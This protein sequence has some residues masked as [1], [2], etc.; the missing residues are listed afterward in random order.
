M[1]Q[2]L[3]NLDFVARSLVQNA[4]CIA[5]NRQVIQAFKQRNRK[6]L[7]QLSINF[8]DSLNEVS[9]YKYFIH[10]HLPGPVS[11][12]RVW[13]PEKYGDDISRFRKMVVNVQQFLKPVWGIELGR[14]GLAVRG[15][16]PVVVYEKGK[17]VLLGSIEVFC[18]LGQVI[19]FTKQSKQKAQG[20]YFVPS[21]KLF[22]STQPIAQTT[23]STFLPW[24]ALPKP[25]DDRLSG[26]FFQ[27]AILGQTYLI[28]NELIFFGMP[29][30]DYANHPVAIYVTCLACPSF[31]IKNVIYAVLIV[32]SILVPII[33]SY[34]FLV[35]TQVI[36][37]LTVLNR[38]LEILRKTSGQRLL[39]PLDASSQL[40][41]LRNA[42]RE[43]ISLANIVNGLILKMDK[44]VSFRRTLEQDNTTA[45]IYARLAWLFKHQFNL[46]NF[47]IF[48]ISNSADKMSPVLSHFEEKGISSS[49]A[50]KPMFCQAARTSL[51]ASTL[52][53]S[54]V[55]SFYSDKIPSACL[56]LQT[57]GRVIAVVRFFITDKRHLSYKLRENLIYNLQPYLDIA[58]GI[59]EMKRYA[60]SLRKTALYDYLTG[61]YNRHM[62]NDC[63]RRI[64]SLARRQNTI[65]G[66]LMLDLDHF[67]RINDTYGHSAGDKILK[68][69]ATIIKQSLR[70]SDVAIRFGGEEFLVFLN[71]TTIEAT[72]MVAERIRT[73]VE[74]TPLTWKDYFINMTI[75]I[76]VA[77]F[78]H[79]GNS[80]LTVT[81]LA[82]KALYQA[83]KTGRNCVVMYKMK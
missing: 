42:S 21:I 10:F 45:D 37:P 80:L 82:D 35:N 24:K 36:R 6:Q 19:A 58:A 67:K 74:D 48:E 43:I 15:I 29:I 13:K 31:F 18:D 20:I 7:L 22:A 38:E 72:Q 9:P 30:F 12:L 17:K 14:V 79:H 44:L 70:E 23:N 69:I 55:C 60:E 73:T 78:P 26:L 41:L 56:P 50:V 2:E 59:I 1:S 32:I 8:L 11:F 71:D 77:I 5:S 39:S 25:Y 33:L 46:K 47:I 27:K 28:K 64:E 81:E 76:G 49:C 62:L 61:F 52:H 3:K 65:V 40:V 75:S 63:I 16:A 4:L 54:E 83:K 68:Q 51:L 57:E 66:V 53:A 34:F